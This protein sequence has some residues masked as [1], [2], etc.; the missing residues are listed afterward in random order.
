MSKA[1]KL[2]EMLESFS[3]LTLKFVKDAGHSDSITPQGLRVYHGTSEK[4]L[5]SILK[6]GKFKGYPFFALDEETATRFG[7][8][9][10]GK[11]AVYEFVVDPE[12][13]IPTGG[14]LTA[15][16]EGL[17]RDEDNVWRVK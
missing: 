2:L 13:V 16:I 7:K 15:R 1:T 11:L 4:N 3:D 14:Y 6:S 8:Q 10:G 17:E 5:K 9:A 12:F